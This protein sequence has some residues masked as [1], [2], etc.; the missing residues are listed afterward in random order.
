[1]R[2]G[3]RNRHAAIVRRH[4]AK[5]DPRRASRRRRRFPEPVNAPAIGAKQPSGTHQQRALP[6]ARTSGDDDDLTA[7]YLQCDAAQRLYAR[8]AAAE[9]YAISLVDAEETECV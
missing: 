7:T 1:M 5:Q 8:S 4:G 2:Q 3:F 6:G 9:A